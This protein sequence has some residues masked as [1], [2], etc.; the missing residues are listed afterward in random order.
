MACFIVLVAFGIGFPVDKTG[1]KAN[2]LNRSLEITAVPW[3]PRQKD[4]DSAKFRV[5]GDKL[6]QKALAGITYRLVAFEYI[7]GGTADKS[8]PTPVATHFRV[9]YY[10]YT[11]DKA[12]LAVGDFAD[13]EPVLIQEAFYDPNVSSEEIAAAISLIKSDGG[14]KGR[15]NEKQFEL[16]E[17]MP[18]VSNLDGERLIN[19]GIRNLS[20]GDN[21]IVGISFKSNT[22]KRYENNA[23]PSVRAA[24]DACGVASSGGST[25]QGVAGQYQ[26]TVTDAG[27]PLWEMLIIRPSSSTGGEGSGI[28]IRDVKYKGK[29]VL[30][31]G[32]VP[33]LN[34][35]YLP[36]GGCD[37]FRDWQYA[38]GFFN[39][40]A[41][42]ASDPGPGFRV[43]A[44]GQ[45]AT[46]VVESGIDA[47]NF[48]GVAVY[49]EDVG[50]GSEV[51]LVTEM[52]AG[53]YR[54]IMEWRFAPDGTIRPRYGFG[55][56]LNSCTCS[57]RNHHVYWRFDFDIVQP[58]NNISRFETAVSRGGKSLIPVST[59]SAFFRNYDTNRGFFINNANGPEA[60][61]IIANRTDQEAFY[62]NPAGSTPAVESFGKGDFWLLKFQGIGS[63]PGELDDPNSSNCPNS[64]D[65]TAICLE[66]WLNNESLVNTDVVLWYGA[67]Q[68]RFDDA[69]LAD[70]TR[71]DVIRGAHVVGPD[72][73]PVR[74]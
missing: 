62:T 22:I 14:S 50:N 24:P 51:V 37:T 29:S 7:E 15:F 21:Q 11:N 20:S 2:T 56:T 38:E 74:W 31:R 32:H 4:V 41:A 70:P 54:Y 35:K 26:M 59:E 49:R 28:E 19:I 69:S 25:G 44:N 58:N 10:D 64:T 68:Y 40:P 66:P 55:S 34:V 48:Q 30:K 17:P 63:S 33:V 72:L 13:K 1:K 46:T 57:P 6:V 43:L 12:I 39:A 61:R 42:G 27:S 53:W 8:Q 16:Y 73:V 3:G 71:P 65:A 18:P 45:I 23:P 67:H 36:N 9:V 5:E 60:Y 47:G 52:N